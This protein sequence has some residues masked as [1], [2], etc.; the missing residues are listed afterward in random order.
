MPMM[1]NGGMKDG[2]IGHR[3]DEH[4]NEEFCDEAD[5]LIRSDDALVAASRRPGKQH[6]LDGW[7]ISQ[8]EDAKAGRDSTPMV[9]G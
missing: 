3:I 6:R 5:E 7:I 1:I 9:R 2:S 4:F 8:L